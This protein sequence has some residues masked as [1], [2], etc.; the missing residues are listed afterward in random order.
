MLGGAG[1]SMMVSREHCWGQHYQIG[2]LVC[3]EIK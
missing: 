2:S 3:L 1:L